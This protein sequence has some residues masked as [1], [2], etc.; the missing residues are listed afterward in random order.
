MNIK[1]KTVYLCGNKS[2]NEHNKVDIAIAEQFLSGTGCIII[3]PLNLE[4]V[5]GELTSAKRSEICHK[6]IEVSD[7]VFMVSGWQKDNTA[8][9]EMYYARTLG[10]KIMY[11][12][13]Y[14]PFRRKGNEDCT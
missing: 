12:D 9:A 6:L 2:D 5:C 10:K 7:I 4:K 11:Q 3:N 1:D 13:Y 14:N 8:N